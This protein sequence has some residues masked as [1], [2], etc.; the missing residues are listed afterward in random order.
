MK[1]VTRHRGSRGVGVART[2]VRVCLVLVA[3]LLLG[4]CDDGPSGPGTFTARVQAPADRPAGA[5][6]I[7]ISGEG[8]DGFRGSGSSQVFG[9]TVRVPTEES[10]EGLYRVVVVAP[11]GSEL[12]F[13]VEM[14]DVALSFPAATLV[15]VADTADAEIAAT[16]DYRVRWER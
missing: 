10:R 4:A 6:V 8:I 15:S 5:A 2:R 13:E 14:E 9:R 3:G 7:E 12:R 1:G 16:G 11:A